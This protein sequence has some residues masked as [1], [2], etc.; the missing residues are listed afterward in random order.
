MI[1]RSNQHMQRPPIA[2]ILTLVMTVLPLC[3]AT[4]ETTRIAVAPCHRPTRSFDPWPGVL[5]WQPDQWIWTGDAV[6][7]DSAVPSVMA[8]HYQALLDKPGYAQLQAHTPIDGVYDDH[9]YGRNNAGKEFPGK[10]HAQQAFL[11]FINVPADD[12]RRQRAGLYH[13]F[14]LGDNGKRVRV[15]MLDTRYHREQPSPTGDILGDEQWAWLVAQLTDSPADIHIVISSI[16]VLAEDHRYESWSRFPASRA[17][18]LAT[19]EAHPVPGLVLVSGDRH[20]GEIARIDRPG[21]YPL[22]EITASG[23]T[24]VWGIS[25]ANQ[26]DIALVLLSIG[27]TSAGS[28]LIGQRVRSH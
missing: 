15:I 9:D 21:T 16:Q 6:Y 7:H 1:H 18:L 10:D 13:S 20:I 5:A 26:T 27:I 24:E 14:D 17:R 3:L 25:P 11:D 22:W 2:L 23:L 4:A 8:Q 19:L 28:S 12:P